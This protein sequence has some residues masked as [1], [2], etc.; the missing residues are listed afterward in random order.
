[1]KWLSV[2][3]G[4]RKFPMKKEGLLNVTVSN[5]RIEKIKEISDPELFNESIQPINL[6]V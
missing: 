4:M 2:D 5:N 1:M 6:F 3:A